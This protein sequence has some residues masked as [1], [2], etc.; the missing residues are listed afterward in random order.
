MRV[1]IP[2]RPK[3]IKTKSDALN[4]CLLKC[5]NACLGCAYECEIRRRW[6]IPPYGDHYYHEE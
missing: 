3:E 5:R 6:R 2:E 1:C 4:Y